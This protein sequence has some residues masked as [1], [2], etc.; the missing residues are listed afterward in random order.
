MDEAACK[1]RYGPNNIRYLVLD[2]AFSKLNFV[3]VEVGNLGSPYVCT[4]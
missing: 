2:L 4:H 1:V 3:F